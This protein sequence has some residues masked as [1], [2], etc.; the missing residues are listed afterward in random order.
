MKR[1]LIDAVLIV[2]AS[3]VMYLMQLPFNTSTFLL[4]LFV[5]GGIAWW[6]E[7]RA[8]ND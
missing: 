2:I 1:Y 7:S 5:G 4:A 6:S 8:S 3:G